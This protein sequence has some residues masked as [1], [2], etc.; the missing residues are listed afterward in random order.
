MQESERKIRFRSQIRKY[1]ENDQ[2]YSEW[3]DDQN[4]AAHIAS[5][6]DSLISAINSHFG[7]KE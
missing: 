5:R 3:H 7:K 6:T 2:M 4:D 1:D